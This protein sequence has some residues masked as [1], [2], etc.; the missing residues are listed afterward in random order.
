M[1]IIEKMKCTEGFWG[2]TAPPLDAGQSCSCRQASK[3]ACR[4]KRGRAPDLCACTKHL[5]GV[6]REW[7]PAYREGLWDTENVLAFSVS[8]TEVLEWFSIEREY[9]VTSLLDSRG[10]RGGAGENSPDW[11][12]MKVSAMA[13]SHGRCYLP[14][15]PAVCQ[16]SSPW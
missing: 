11:W 5:A 2:W 10:Q 1:N 9:C 14:P 16:T 6:Y 3:Q 13:I 15:Q 4:P 8:E 7:P 12:H